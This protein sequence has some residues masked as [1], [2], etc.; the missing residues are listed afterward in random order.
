M[1]RK[2]KPDM[3]MSLYEMLSILLDS[4][5][6]DGVMTLHFDSCGKLVKIEDIFVYK[7]VT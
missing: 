5:Q 3:N 2:V 6:S 4:R 7:E 1:A